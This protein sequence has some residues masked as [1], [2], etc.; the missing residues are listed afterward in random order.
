VWRRVGCKD[1]RVVERILRAAHSFEEV[2]EFDRQDMARLSLEERV[3]AV[4]QLR[5]TWFGEARAQSRLDRILVA[6]NLEARY[7]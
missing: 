1:C 3:S 4:E 5:R 6:T 7:T 2:E